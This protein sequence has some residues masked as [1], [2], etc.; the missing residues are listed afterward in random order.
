M[1]LKKKEIIITLIIVLLSFL[2]RLYRLDIPHEW[3][4]DEVYHALSAEAYALNDPRGYEWFNSS[5]K[6]LA[7]EWL[8]PPIGTLFAALTVWLLIRFGEK[9]FGSFWIGAVA[10]GLYALDGLSFVQSRTGM[11]DIYVTFFVVLA[12]YRL[13]IFIKEYSLVGP[14]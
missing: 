3:S 11:N 5:P 2:I 4:F 8:H 14:A 12:F 9:L 10:G 6:D 7:W 13:V 1:K